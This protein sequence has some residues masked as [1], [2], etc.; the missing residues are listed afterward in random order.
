MSGGLYQ[1]TRNDTDLTDD[2]FYYFID[3]ARNEQL[4]RVQ[5]NTWSAWNRGGS[6][7][8]VYDGR[9]STGAGACIHAGPRINL[10]AKWKD[11]ISSFRFA[12]RSSCDR[13]EEL[14][15]ANG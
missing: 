12:T 8:V 2:T 10:P 9:A 13:Y 5:R 15:D 14:A 6:D 11:R 4:P 3:P 1:S 7:V